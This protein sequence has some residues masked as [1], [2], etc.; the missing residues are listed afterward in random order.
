MPNDWRDLP[1]FAH[2]TVRPGLELR[3]L[4][5][6][7]AGAVL[8][9]LTDDPGIRD[10]VKVVAEAT[11]ID[12]IQDIADT[13]QV[14]PASAH[15]VIVSD[16]AVVGSLSLWRAGEHFGN[17]PVD[18]DSFGF[19]YFLTP[20][21]R[22]R[23]IIPAVLQVV[24][25]TTRQH[26]P[27]HSFVAFCEDDNPASSRNL[28]KAGLQPT[29]V[30]FTNSKGWRERLYERPKTGPRASEAMLGTTPMAEHVYIHGHHESVLRS[31]RSRTAQN[32]AGYLL[33]HLRP[34][35]KLLDVGSGP[36]TITCD[37]AGLVGEVVALEQG[38]AALALTLAEATRR[39]VENVTGRIGDVHHLPFDDDSFDVVH[40][41]QVLQHVSDP[42][43]ALREMARV[44][45]PGGLIAARDSDYSMFTWAPAAPALEEWLATYRR[46]ARCSGGEPDAGRHYAEWA[47]AAGL[48]D[49]TFTSSAWTYATP[50]ERQWWSDMW[51]TR[52][53]ASTFATQAHAN[54][55]GQETLERLSQ[56]WKAWGQ[57]PHGLFIVPSVELLARKPTG[58]R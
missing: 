9:I 23:G 42:I 26:V 50:D 38:D 52:V 12:D 36:G 14:S 58:Q 55:I 47:A 49:A 10:R 13:R 51:A 20:T 31:H 40:A 15:F 43:Q 44:T 4:T 25:E 7:D 54:G 16:E 11:T 17:L 24:M 33:P 21:A 39:S 2:M 46:L 22:G 37:L 35:M 19:G 48:D 1:A 32:S 45:R 8:Q 18:P 57:E 29:P 27:V 30:A 6:A 28:E 34:G 53:L 56:G 41:H 5:S 3:R